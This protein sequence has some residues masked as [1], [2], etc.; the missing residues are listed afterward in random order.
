[1]CGRYS[2]ADLDDLSDRFKLAN[3]APNL[4]PH[5]NVSPTQTMPVVVRADDGNRV[6]L[7][8]WGLIPSWHK[9]GKGFI[10]ARAETASAKP[11]FKRAYRTRRCIVPAL[12]FFEWKQTSEGKVPYL[13]Q[14]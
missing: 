7:M 8:D 10:N 4:K 6:E 5:Y 1:M 11:S 14:T 12:S 3:D 13:I 9:K 2:L